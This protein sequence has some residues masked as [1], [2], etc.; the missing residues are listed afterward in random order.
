MRRIR[1]A[2]APRP[3]ATGKLLVAEGTSQAGAVPAGVPTILATTAITT[4]TAQRL[5]VAATAFLQDVVDTQTVTLEIR[6][7]GVVID[8]GVVTVTAATPALFMRSILT[9]ALAAGVHT[10]DVRAQPS[11]ADLSVADSGAR[12]NLIAVM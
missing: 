12:V 3:P 2:L 1:I 9:N 11:V 7:D 6:V 8:S 10:V 5:R 4:P